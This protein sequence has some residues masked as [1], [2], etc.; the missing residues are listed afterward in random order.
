MAESI[1]WKRVLETLD[2]RQ[3]ATEQGALETTGGVEPIDLSDRGIQSRVEDLRSRLRRYAEEWLADDPAAL[4]VIDQIARQ[5][6]AGLRLF[7][8]DRDGVEA[9]LDAMSGLESVIKADHSRPSF[10]VS[11]GRIVP[12]SSFVE[13]QEWEDTF[14]DPV[15]ASHLACALECVGRIDMSDQTIQGATVGT[16]FLIRE[17]LLVTNNHVVTRFAEPE[18]TE[19]RF[20]PNTTAWV[21]FGREYPSATSKRVRRIEEVCFAGSLPILGMNHFLPDLAIVRLEP[22][23]QI[24]SSVCFSW[25]KL[26]V[27]SVPLQMALDIV[28]MGYP[29]ESPDSSSQLPVG[30]PPDLLKQLFQ[31]QLGLK[32]LAVG[33]VTSRQ[34]N[35]QWAIEHDASTLA[36]NSGSPL[37]ALP[38]LEV[39]SGLHYGGSAGF[40]N[41]AGCLPDM[42][43][44]QGISGETLGSFLTRSQVEFV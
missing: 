30:S 12:N 18:S 6:E 15:L 17:N 37:F 34:T 25:F 42:L 44:M 20:K 9:N 31:L 3:N 16:G 35:S 4:G 13:G 24:P 41:F 8:D 29:C 40:A 1:R 32:R 39:V 5:G 21:D 22:S 19:W 38:S 7:R 33:Q 36:G 2:Q 10:L 26:P 11:D 28:L 14:R 43:Q 23:H 27:S